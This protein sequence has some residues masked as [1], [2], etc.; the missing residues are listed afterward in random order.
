MFIGKYVFALTFLVAPLWGFCGSET[1]IYIFTDFA[2]GNPTDQPVNDWQTAIELSAEG[3]KLTNHP[4]VFVNDGA[5]PLNPGKA[6]AQLAKAFPYL[7]DHLQDKI[8]RIVIHV[9][10]PGVGN[11]SQH[12]RALVLR[13][14]GTLFIGPDNGTLSLACPSGSIRAVW[15]IDTKKISNF[16]GIDLEAGGTFHGRDVFAAAAY[17]LAAEKVAINAIGKRYLAPELQFR[18]DT[19]HE[20]K[21]LQ[22][23][24]VS[25]SRWMV[26]LDPAPSEGEL[27]AKAYFL[28]IVQSPFWTE[29]GSPQLFFI[30]DEGV[31][32]PIAI[33][34][35]KTRNL[36]VGPDNGLGTSFF[37]G[38]GP[39]EILAVELHESDLRKIEASE[40]VQ[41]AV[42]LI[43]NKQ[44]IR[45]P[46]ATIDLLA[47]EL[48]SPEK[49]QCVV[50]GRIWI[51]AY[52]NIKT[53]LDNALFSKVLG[54]EFKE[55][56]VHLNGV[57]RSVRIG[58]SFANIP[59]GEPF[60]YV[61]S[62]GTVGPNPRRSK[63]Y[64]ELSCNGIE[65]SFGTDLFKNGDEAPY[66]GQKIL[67]HFKK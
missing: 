14:D 57:A 27:F 6:G 10:D 56:S 16:I 12:P 50:E 15:E 45:R 58:D 31:G 35:R 40:D 25:T 65:G 36:Y 19:E 61:G 43:L 63:R 41:A 60:V 3:G 46:L 28:S 54:Q 64:L 49:N 47:H 13:K 2:G 8:K 18:A 38:Y 22:F 20:A 33:Y 48:V 30:D 53:S 26:P 44:P 39:E 21:P 32:G 7:G 55:L 62:S 17:L 23:E 24:R 42:D 37:Y 9:I 34:N 67:F 66:N 52:G 51:D 29:E 59:P 4:E 11:A 5:V 1:E